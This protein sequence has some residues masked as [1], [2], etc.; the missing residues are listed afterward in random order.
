MKDRNAT[1]ILILAYGMGQGSTFALLLVT[2]NYV[3]AAA[4]GILVLALSIVSFAQQFGEIGNN[5][6]LLSK[7]N[8]G[9]MN[10]VTAQL[11]TRSIA[12][13]LILSIFCV[14]THLTLTAAIAAEIKPILLV[15]PFI[16]LLL[17]SNCSFLYEVNRQYAT[18]ALTTVRLWILVSFSLASAVFFDNY[19]WATVLL[20]LALLGHFLQITRPFSNVNLR[21]IWFCWGERPLF[22]IQIIPIIAAAVA[23]QIWYRSQILIIADN[24]GLAQLASLGIVRSIQIAGILVTGF[25]IRPILQRKLAAS[26]NRESPIRLAEMIRS[27]KMPLIALTSISILCIVF[28]TIFLPQPS[29]LAYWI[30]LFYGLPLAAAAI[31]ATQLNSIHLTAKKMFALDHLGLLLNIITFFS[32][33][34]INLPMAIVLGEIIQHLWTVTS[35]LLLEKN[36]RQ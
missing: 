21:S 3:D 20:S 14:W 29:S 34:R 11:R 17:G 24:A 6:L 36:Q 35:R 18:L 16:A 32:V 27:F 5:P 15:A 33:M 12:G 4:A 9:D 26:L 22:G 13:F 19:T 8:T 2:R 23:G 25:A 7:G 10:G 28:G 31:I 1:A 30:P